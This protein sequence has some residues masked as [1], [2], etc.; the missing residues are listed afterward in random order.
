MLEEICIHPTGAQP[1][2]TAESTVAVDPSLNATT[3]LVC[4][5]FNTSEV[6]EELSFPC[7]FLD[8]YYAIVGSR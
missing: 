4:L 3:G 8:L 1:V 7:L 5:V 6:W 2:E